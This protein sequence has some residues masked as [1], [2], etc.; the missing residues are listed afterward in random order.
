MT[1]TR[2]SGEKNISIFVTKLIFPRI[3]VKILELN[4][5]TLIYDKHNNLTFVMLIK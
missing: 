4:Q 1:C 5:F 2:N 3:I